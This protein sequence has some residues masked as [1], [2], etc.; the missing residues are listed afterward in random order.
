MAVR[1]CCTGRNT[2]ANHTPCRHP[3]T[4]VRPKMHI[5]VTTNRVTTSGIMSKAR[6]I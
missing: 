5:P 6:L 4:F 3:P 2:T 1:M